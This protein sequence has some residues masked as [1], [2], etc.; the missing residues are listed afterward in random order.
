MRHC[1]LMDIEY[2]PSRSP[3]KACSRL[4]GGTFRSFIVTGNVTLVKIHQECAPVRSSSQGSTPLRPV[5]D[6]SFTGSPLPSALR[7]RLAHP[8]RNR[9]FNTSLISFSKRFTITSDT[10]FCLYSSIG[11]LRFAVSSSRGSAEPALALGPSKR[12]AFFG[13][14]KRNVR[15]TYSPRTR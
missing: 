3:F 1:S 9:I 4:L 14:V 7:S 12:F 2:C 8:S 5:L 10:A 13:P 6:F 15:R 11:R